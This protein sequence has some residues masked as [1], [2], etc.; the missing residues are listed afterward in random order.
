[1]KS[2]PTQHR[3]LGAAVLADAIYPKRMLCNALGSGDRHR[4]SMRHGRGFAWSDSGKTN[5]LGRDVLSFFPTAG[6]RPGRRRQRSE[7]RERRIVKKK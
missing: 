5:L 1:M 4:G 3:P 2:P 7:R 6:R